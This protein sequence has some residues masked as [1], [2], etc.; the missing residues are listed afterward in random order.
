MST[1]GTSEY[2]YDADKGKRDIDMTEFSYPFQINDSG[3]VAT[4]RKDQH[5]LQLVE[6]VLLTVQGERVNR[7]T[8]ELILPN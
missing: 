7:P 2:C 8:L 4:V 1:R 6:E 3:G 5:I